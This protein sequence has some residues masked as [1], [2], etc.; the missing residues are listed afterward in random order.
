[1][2]SLNKLRLIL[3]FFLV[4]ILL[5]GIILYVNFS[6]SPRPTDEN[7]LRQETSI[8]EMAKLALK[9]LP[10]NP[11]D[12]Q[13]KTRL[14]AAKKAAQESE[15]VSI[16]DCLANPPVLK[17][18]FSKMILFRNRDKTSHLIK[19]SDKTVSLP[20]GKLESVV[21]NFSQGPGLYGYS[22]DNQ[23]FLSGLILLE[24]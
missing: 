8:N 23:G 13:R 16:L 7:R 4:T 14:E 6:K 21:L 22:C 19:F 24:K 20:M 10:K 15:V 11:T 3:I 18:K 1:M 9:P 5:V 12:E 17:A 2:F